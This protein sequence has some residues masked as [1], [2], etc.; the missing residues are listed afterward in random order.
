MESHDH[1]CTVTRMTPAMG[2]GRFHVF[3]RYVWQEP[4]EPDWRFG[5]FHSNDLIERAI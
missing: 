2:K 3:A 1:P 4:C 5:T